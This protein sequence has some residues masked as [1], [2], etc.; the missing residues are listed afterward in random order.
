MARKPNYSKYGFSLDNIESMMTPDGLATQADVYFDGQLLGSWYDDACSI[1]PRMF[2]LAEKLGDKLIEQ[3]PEY[4]TVDGKPVDYITGGM[5]I[6]QLFCEIADAHDAGL[7]GSVGEKLAGC[8]P[9]LAAISENNE[10]LR[11]MLQRLEER[12]KKGV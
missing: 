10:R 8:E 12:N 9:I 11:E 5:A 7:R 1:V 3:H 4:R 2:P 6:G